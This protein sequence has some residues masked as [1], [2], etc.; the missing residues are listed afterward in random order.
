MPGEILVPEYIDEGRLYT[1]GGRVLNVVGLGDDLK[2]AQNA[3]YENIT[4]IHF[5]YEYYRKDIGEV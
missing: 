3:A 4:K 1:S 5:D 2:S